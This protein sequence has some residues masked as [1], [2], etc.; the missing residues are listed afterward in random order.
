MLNCG[1]MSEQKNCVFLLPRGD[2]PIVEVCKKAGIPDKIREIVQEA[3]K[4][5]LEVITMKRINR[6][7]L[8]RISIEGSTFTLC[9]YA[10]IIDVYRVI[11]QYVYLDEI[12]HDY[13]EKIRELVDALLKRTK[14]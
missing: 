5:V 14:K 9:E 3:H 1:I 8:G 12:G 7:L 13:K 10:E 4:Q 2:E 11:E 6:Q